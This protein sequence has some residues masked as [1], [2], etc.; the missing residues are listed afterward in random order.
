MDVTEVSI[1]RQSNVYC[2]FDFR[3][4][5][6]QKEPSFVRPHVLLT[7]KPNGTSRCGSALQLVHMHHPDA[8]TSVARGISVVLFALRGG[9]VKH[10]I[11][12]RAKATGKERQKQKPRKITKGG[13]RGDGR[14][15]GGSG[16]TCMVPYS[17]NMNK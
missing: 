2:D 7:G 15:G 1:F 9:Q 11:K 6:A 3:R 16:G 17:T 14:V 5:V 12:D 4:A 8:N 13:G 10:T